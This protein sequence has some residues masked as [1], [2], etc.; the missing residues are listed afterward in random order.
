VA[1]D[2]FK[3]LKLENEGFI[4]GCVV[5]ISGVKSQVPAVD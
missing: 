1:I 2:P 3:Y 4:T 5:S